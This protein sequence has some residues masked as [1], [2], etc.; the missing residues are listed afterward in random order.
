MNA[1]ELIKAINMNI[2]DNVTFSGYFDKNNNPI[3]VGDI[4]KFYFDAD[5]GHGDKNNGYTE[6]I[7]VCWRDKKTGTFF[8][9]S[10]MGNGALVFRHNKY[11]E[12]IGNV[13]KDRALLEYFSTGQL[14]KLFPEIK[15]I[16]RNRGK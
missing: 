16:K 10:D 6:M 9:I 14:K 4:V 15:L 3:N 13:K 7:D 12:V 2:G 8:L 11:C 1:Q 5:Y